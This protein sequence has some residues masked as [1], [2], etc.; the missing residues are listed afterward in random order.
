MWARGTLPGTSTLLIKLFPNEATLGGGCQVNTQVTHG[1]DRLI[2]LAEEDLG[3]K[4]LMYGG[5]LR[6]TVGSERG[7]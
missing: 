3:W 7:W 2:S 1:Q 6:G 5:L 4:G